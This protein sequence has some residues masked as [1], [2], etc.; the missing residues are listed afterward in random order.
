M[1]QNE[2]YFLFG[3]VKKVGVQGLR[4]VRNHGLL[5]V[6]EV[7]EHKHNAEITLFVSSD[8]YSP[9]IALYA[10]APIKF[11]TSEGSES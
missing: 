11:S 1:I 2:M 7:F 5:E 3:A 10:S 9:I 8:N 4:S 6:N